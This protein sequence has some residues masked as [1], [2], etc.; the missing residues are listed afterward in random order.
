MKTFQIDFEPIG[1]RVSIHGGESLLTA[2]QQAGIA[3]T[4]VCGGVGV[5]GACKV[6]LVNGQLSPPTEKEQKLFSASDLAVGWRLACR[7]YP[8]SDVKVE[9]PPESLSSTQRLQTEG[10]DCDLALAP[11][12]KTD[13]FEIQTPYSNDLRADWERFTLAFSRGVDSECVPL[14]VLTQFSNL[15]REE[16][17]QGK[18][19]RHE[20]GK[21]IGFL[22]KRRRIF[23]LAV[24]IGTTKMAAYLVDLTTGET[25]ARKGEMNPQIAFGEDVVAR[26]AYANQGEANRNELQNRLVERLN[27]MLVTLSGQVDVDINQVVDVVIVGNTAMHHLFAGLP[28]RQLGQVPY[29]AAVGQALTFPAREVGLKATPNAQVYLPPNIAGYVGA[30]HVA[31]LLA[32]GISS[33]SGVSVALD[34]GT[35]TEISLSKNGH[36]VS[37]SCASGP[38][39]EGAHIHAGMRAV[40][41]A[42]ERAQFFDSKWHLVTVENKPPVGICGSGILDIVS[43][44]LVSGQIDETGRFSDKVH[45]L[46][47]F[48]TG[49]AIELVPAAESGTGRA[50]LVTRKDVREIQLAKAAIRAGVDVL[51]THTG[52]K[53]DEIDHFLIAG[54]FGTY[55]TLQSAIRIGMFPDIPEKRFNQIGNAAGTGARMMLLSGESRKTAE[56]ILDHMQYIELTSEPAFMDLYV[57]AMN[58][59]YFKEKE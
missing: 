55:L 46:V 19:I 23:G 20:N 26:I 51:L 24:D 34:I 13:Q 49:D 2:A 36:L 9:V 54:A 17:W 10:I 38:A 16:G 8:L 5:C 4:A 22:P 6:K 41:G 7:A 29:V 37:C 56:M 35:N 58:F 12:V 59:S 25:V 28:V 44:L 43:E 14:P 52:T 27:E 33:L 11:V 15:M 50:I 57:D 18:V 48:K 53:E 39:F 40:P 45:H 47:P 32:S 1:R 30:D 21:V 31:M 3:L 42:I